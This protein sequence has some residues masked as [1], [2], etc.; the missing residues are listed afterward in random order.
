MK[1]INLFFCAAL[2]ALSAGL[3]ACNTTCAS[4]QSPSSAVANA[5]KKDI[6]L[7]LYSLRSDMKKDPKGT[8]K[9]AGEMGYTA[10]EAAGYSDGKFYGM[11]P[12][13]FKA[14]VEKA[15]MKVR[16]SHT[17][18]KLS[19]E[20]VKNNNFSES[21]KWWEKAIPAHKA[22]G[23]EYIVV[24]SIPFP[25]NI[26]EMQLYCDY[27]NAVGKMCKDAGIK[28]GYHNHSFEMKPVKDKLSMYEYMLQ[29][30]NPENVFFEM[31]VYWAVMGQQSPVELF[32]KYPNRFR[33][34]HIK[35]LKELGESGMVGFDAIF[36]NAHIG[37]VEGIV[38]EVERYNYEPAKSVK[39]SYDYLNNAPFVPATYPKK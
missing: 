24:P 39:L 36:K 1:Y 34:L 31:D 22:T 32:K 17:S 23:M 33:L 6:T 2:I 4:A 35:D 12:E 21:L 9:K 27:L 7:Q 14:E 19:P 13:E 18:K 30:T 26:K 11:T 25:K 29:N 20:E 10:V 28:F 8:I 16:S 5:P 3:T 38:V 37:G 15:G